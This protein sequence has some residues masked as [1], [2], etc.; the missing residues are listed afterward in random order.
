M[1]ANP[2]GTFGRQNGKSGAYIR[3]DQYQSKQQYAD[4][5]ELI[6]DEDAYTEIVESQRYS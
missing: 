1:K 4:V 6:E 2:S 5:M 3:E